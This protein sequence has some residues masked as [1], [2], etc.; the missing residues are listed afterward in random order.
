MGEVFEFVVE[1][2]VCV[3]KVV[4]LLRIVAAALVHQTVIIV[5]AAFALPLSGKIVLI[6]IFL[7]SVVI[8]PIAFVL[9]VVKGILHILLGLV[10]RIRRDCRTSVAFI[11]KARILEKKRLFSLLL[12]R[13]GTVWV[14]GVAVVIVLV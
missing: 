5:A 10:L 4:E 12:L 3:L 14:L 11:G 8:V 13:I 9:T 1:I 7:L 6:V 2:F